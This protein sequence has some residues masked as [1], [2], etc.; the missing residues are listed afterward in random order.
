MGK[1]ICELSLLISAGVLEAFGPICGKWGRFV[2][3]A[4]EELS[5]CAEPN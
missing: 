2:V 1:L 3:P 4:R 5:V